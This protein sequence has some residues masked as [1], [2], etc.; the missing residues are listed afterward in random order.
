MTAEISP[1]QREAVTALAQG[2]TF[3]QAGAEFD[4]TAVAFKE[5][6]ARL[7]RR[8]Q[9]HGTTAAA[10][11]F[12]ARCGV[13]DGVDL[14]EQRDVRLAP[15]QRDVLRLLGEELSNREIATRL[16]LRETTVHT[17]LARVFK[18][19]GARTRSHAVALDWRWQ[20]SQDGAR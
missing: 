6:L 16:G 19:I 7:Q 13:L 18:L 12:G 8:H 14:G 9:L 10:V 11:A 15:R 20:Y 5:R 1:G 4:S 17:H 2:L 3:S